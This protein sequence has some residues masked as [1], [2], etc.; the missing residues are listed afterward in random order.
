MF[1]AS[2]SLS[3]SLLFIDFVNAFLAFRQH[4]DKLFRS[5]KTK[6]SFQVEDVVFSVGIPN[7]L[8]AGLSV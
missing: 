6:N 8:S 4:V 2:L 7:F 1:V 5:L 3:L